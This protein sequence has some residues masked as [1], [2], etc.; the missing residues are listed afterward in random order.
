MGSRTVS[1]DDVGLRI[2]GEKLS[3]SKEFLG[4]RR[5]QSSRVNEEQHFQQFKVVQLCVE[6]VRKRIEEYFRSK[7]VPRRIEEAVEV[8]EREIGERI[9]SLRMMIGASG[10]VADMEVV[11]GS[12]KK[13]Y[14][15]RKWKKAVMEVMEERV[16]KR[17]IE[18]GHYD[19]E[20]GRMEDLFG[21]WSGRRED[22]KDR[23]LERRESRIC[24][25]CGERGHLKKDCGR[26]KKDKGFQGRDL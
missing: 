26:A 6:E 17:E 13:D 10:L 7:E 15:V 18:V 12:L 14:D 9:M 20:R 19:R 16:K 8:C 24:H 23:R 11:G 1:L 2:K 25:A 22:S 21:G 3:G 5:G 4:D